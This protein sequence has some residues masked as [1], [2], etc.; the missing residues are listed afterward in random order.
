MSLE[1]LK[2]LNMDRVLDNDEA[3][4]LSAFARQQM[5]E[6]ETLEQPIPDWLG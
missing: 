5:T 1:K 3:V 2:N 6:Y 4:A